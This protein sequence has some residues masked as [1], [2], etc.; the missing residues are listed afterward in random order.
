M[1]PGKQVGVTIPDS[2]LASERGTPNTV[3]H[4]LKGETFAVNYVDEQGRVRAAV[5]TKFG[6]TVYF[7]ANSEQWASQLRPASDWMQKAIESKIIHLSTEDIPKE[8]TVDVV[9]LQV[10]AGG[11]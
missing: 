10:A 7:A 2:Q 3:L 1:F 5:V 4:V 6:D 8:D 9:A 11:Q